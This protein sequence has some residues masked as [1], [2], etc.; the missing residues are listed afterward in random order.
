MSILSVRRTVTVSTSPVADT[1]VTPGIRAT[2]R[3]AVAGSVAGSPGQRAAGRDGQH[4]RAELLDLGEQ[5]G[6]ADRADPDQ[7]DH[8]GH[9]DRDAERGQ[10]RPQRPSVEPAEPDRGQIDEAKPR[11]LRQGAQATTIVRQID[12]AITVVS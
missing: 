7:A 3:S 8:R 2:I 10:H 11:R 6:P 5:R 4:V 12:H 1:P 9:P